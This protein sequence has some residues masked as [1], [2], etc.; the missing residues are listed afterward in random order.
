MTKK[1]IEL[2]ILIGIR[3]TNEQIIAL[4]DLMKLKSKQVNRRVDRSELVRECIDA[5]LKIIYTK[6]TKR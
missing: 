5:G 3:T 2:P 1:K 6:Y 4:E